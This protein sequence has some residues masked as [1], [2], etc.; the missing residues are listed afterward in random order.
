MP[1]ITLI[2]LFDPLYQ[3]LINAVHNHLNSLG[4]ELKWLCKSIIRNPLRNILAK[5]KW[6]CLI[7]F[8]LSGIVANRVLPKMTSTIGNW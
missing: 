3:H 8:W 4:L 5:I 1:R 2:N 6:H 7:A